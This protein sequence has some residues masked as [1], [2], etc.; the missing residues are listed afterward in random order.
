MLR[1]RFLTPI[2][3]L[4]LLVGCNSEDPR[5]PQKLLEDARAL[6][7]S[8]KPVEARSML[9]RIAQRYPETAAGK[10]AQQDLFI[11][12]VSLKQ[13]MQEK[14][15]L[16][17]ASMKRIMDALERYKTKH[18]EFPWTLQALVPDHLDLV[19]ET[20]WGHPFLYRPFVPMP[21]EELRDRRGALSQRFNTKFEAYHFA[22]L[23][24]DLKPGGDELARD[25]L[26]ITGEFSKEAI[27]P[28]IP[29]PQPFK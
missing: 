23:G 25:T 8:G 29:M 24:T 17:R 7:N 12:Q 2:A 21:I 4:F 22:C 15:R 27:L 19:P 13:E 28:P 10:Q 16:V 9:E 6:S 5:L 26:A 11:I 20:P 18:G 3:C 14:Q 1:P